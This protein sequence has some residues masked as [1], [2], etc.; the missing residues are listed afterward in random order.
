MIA[1]ASI[2]LQQQEMPMQTVKFTFVNSEE[3]LDKVLK[4]PGQ[5]HVEHFIAKTLHAGPS[6]WVGGH[7]DFT[8]LTR[9]RTE[10]GA[11]IVQDAWGTLYSRMDAMERRLGL[12]ESMFREVNLTMELGDD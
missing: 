8:N 10:L 12:L 7:G 1:R 5:H 6:L 2:I 9:V 11:P 3:E 4:I